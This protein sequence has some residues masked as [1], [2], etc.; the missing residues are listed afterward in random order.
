MIHRVLIIFLTTTLLLI[1]LEANSQ[2]FYGGLQLGINGSQINGDHM[3]G[4][5]KGGLLAGVFID[6]PYS[7]RVFFTMELNYTEKGSRSKDGTM[8]T[9]GSWTLFKIS[10]LEVPLFINYKLSEKA[11]LN[12]GLSFGLKVGHNYIDSLGTEDPNYDFTHPYDFGIC[13]GG[14][15]KL[16]N[17]FKLSLRAGASLITIGTGKSNPFWAKRN[18]GFINIVISG[19]IKYYFLSPK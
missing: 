9:A 13:G 16:G 10:Y 17:K 11:D 6:Y 3:S 14:N 7:Q 18:S 1:C 2:K 15:Y 19:A 4:F 5:D 12:I 8:Q